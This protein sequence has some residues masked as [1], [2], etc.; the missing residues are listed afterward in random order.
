M[1]KA[2]I[3]EYS[4]LSVITLTSQQLL[5]QLRIKGF[6]PR[7]SIIFNSKIEGYKQHIINNIEIY[8]ELYFNA[9][10]AN[11]VEALDILDKN[12]NLNEDEKLNL[13]KSFN[14][15][16][17]NNND[18]L[19][20]YLKEQK[21][22]T[23]NINDIITY[24][25]LIKILNIQLNEIQ[26]SFDKNKKNICNNKKISSKEQKTKIGALIKKFKKNEKKLLE[27]IDYVKGLC[28]PEE[29]LLNEICTTFIKAIYNENEG[30]FIK[31]NQLLTNAINFSDLYEDYQILV[32]IIL[33]SNGSYYSENSIEF[34]KKFIETNVYKSLPFETKINFLSNLNSICIFA[35]SEE[36]RVGKEC[37]S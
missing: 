12:I 33:I 9:L 32:N 36:R 14:N 24:N 29:T 37:S 11:E 3:K 2:E 20:L 13:T 22:F 5:D 21:W 17:K 1:S 18:K 28:D 35:R 27:D 15:M 23:Y 31:L 34:T 10:S 30:D 16:F 25:D 8:Y 7:K 6:G 26:E 19:F 4:P